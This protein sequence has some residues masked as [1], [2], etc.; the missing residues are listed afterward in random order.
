MEQLFD[1]NLYKDQDFI[2]MN[3]SRGGEVLLI[4][5]KSVEIIYKVKVFDQTWALVET[6][7]VFFG[8]SLSCHLGT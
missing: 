8:I 5:K 3:N 1:F 2:Y 4:T 6:F 7:L